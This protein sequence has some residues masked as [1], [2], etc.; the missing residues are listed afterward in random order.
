MIEH[1]KEAHT[2]GCVSY[3]HPTAYRNERKK[4]NKANIYS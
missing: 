4:T 2:G 1:K 3:E